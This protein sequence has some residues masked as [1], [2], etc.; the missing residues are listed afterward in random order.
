MM[1][2]DIAQE[3]RDAVAEELFA[4]AYRRHVLNPAR[5]GSQA[6]LAQA[7]GL[8]A[9]EVNRLKKDG[10]IKALLAL[11]GELGM[12][13]IINPK[14]VN[15]IDPVKPKPFATAAELGCGMRGGGRR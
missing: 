8:R 9:Q 10:S 7:L 13:V 12:T 5:Y 4:A 6:L 3:Q 11:A 1:N 15:I 2:N 14:Q